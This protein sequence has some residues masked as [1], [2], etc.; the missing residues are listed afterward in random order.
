MTATVKAAKAA[1]WYPDGSYG[2]WCGLDPQNSGP[3]LPPDFNSLAL[4]QF[5]DM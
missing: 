5:L 3:A 4:Q 2:E 1:S